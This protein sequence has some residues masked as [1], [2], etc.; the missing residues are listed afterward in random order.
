VPVSGVAADRRAS[1]PVTE[2]AA[3]T[4]SGGRLARL[5]LG[6]RSLGGGE[7]AVAAL[8]LGVIALVAFGGHVRHGGFYYDDWGVLGIVRFRAHG[9]SAI[10]A[11]WPFYSKRPGEVVWYALVDSTLGF[12]ASLQLALAAATLTLELLAIFALMR[13]LG[14]AFLH[15]LLI[16]ALIL[17]F[18][19]SD[20]Q[21]LWAIMSM[22]TLACAIGVLAVILAI[23]ALES[24]GRRALALHAASLLLFVASILS[25]EVFA[26]L[27][28]LAGAAYAV[29]VGLRRARVRWALDVVVI[30]GTLL[31]AKLWLPADRAT[32]V[33]TQSTSSIAH[34]AWLI[35]KQGANVISAATTPSGSLGEPLVLGAIALVLGAAALAAWR[36]PAS[37]A[38]RP[39]LRRWLSIA[40]VG[41]IVAAAAWA[42]YLPAIDYYSPGSAGTG[43]RVNG[44]AGVGVVLFL[45][46]TGVLFAALLWRLLRPTD[47]G[48]RLAAWPLSP[49]AAVVLGALVLGGGYVRHA[50][51]DA[52]VW[53]EAIVEQRRVL[54]TIKALL[55]HPRARPV[56]LYAFDYPRQVR[57]WIGVFA[58]PW[59]LSSAL[60]HAYGFTGVGGIPTGRGASFECAT[61]AFYPTN[62]GY[63]RALGS[64]YGHAYFVDVA[65]R[66]AVAVDDRSTCLH[67]TRALRAGASI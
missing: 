32:P 5:L 40:V 54:A 61:S 51:S 41:S 53:N 34:H 13:M 28:C 47:W 14:L 65:A 55:P 58:Y 48:R 24:R 10:G 44:M 27:G 11:L 39:V 8:V 64:P 63:G 49:V 26:V 19:F 29:R 50:R 59:D 43:N 4:G 25:Y 1:G 12:H 18:P 60:V 46:S 56:S 62:F 7:L 38:V 67:V 45:Y 23:K 31:A 37:D 3:L 20:S 30:L 52:R 17:V 35:V 2:R 57:T 22:A 36:L 9:Q 33:T 6:R 42:V 15:S 16:C 66:R 21:W